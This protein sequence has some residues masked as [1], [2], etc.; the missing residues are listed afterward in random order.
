MY[1]FIKHIA[2]RKTE[3]FPEKCKLLQYVYSCLYAVKKFYENKILIKKQNMLI[4]NRIF[5]VFGFVL[6][7]KTLYFNI[8]LLL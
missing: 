1:H 2:N 3:Y 7:G 4:K 8:T 6:N 5:C